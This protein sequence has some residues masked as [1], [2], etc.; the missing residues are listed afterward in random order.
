M[1]EIFVIFSHMIVKS[2]VIQNHIK[3][4]VLCTV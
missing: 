2:E 4:V 3:Y 1:F